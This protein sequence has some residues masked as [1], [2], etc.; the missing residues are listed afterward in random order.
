M[1]T[2]MH[3]QTATDLDDL[4]ARYAGRLRN[5]AAEQ[6]AAIT[7]VD[8]AEDLVEQVWE[9]VSGDLYPE[10]RRGLD[11]LLV[12]LRD[13]LRTVRTRAA[14]ASRAIREVVIDPDDLDDAPAASI[15]TLRPLPATVSA[16]VA[17]LRT[18]PLAG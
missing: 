4:Y 2:M 1:D 18:L 14:A 8:L 6:L 17:A 3:R 5:E 16:A 11:G 13:K 15:S 10:G 7:T 9:D 12:L